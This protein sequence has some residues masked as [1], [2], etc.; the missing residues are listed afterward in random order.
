MMGL[1][2]GRGSHTSEEQVEVEKRE[3][4]GFISSRGFCLLV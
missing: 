1:K 2:M 3:G 4:K